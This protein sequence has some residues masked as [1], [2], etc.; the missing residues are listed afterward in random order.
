MAQFISSNAKLQ[1]DLLLR[2]IILGEV[3]YCKLCLS[4]SP[5]LKIDCINKS[6][7]LVL[8][9]TFTQEGNQVKHLLSKAYFN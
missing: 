9:K 1:Q 3:L 7:Y 8:G 5:S 6:L 4:T 2:Q